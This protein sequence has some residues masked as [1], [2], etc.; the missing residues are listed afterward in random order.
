M[1]LF[2]LKNPQFRCVSQI[3]EEAESY[4]LTYE[5]V[6]KKMD[7]SSKNSVKAPAIIVS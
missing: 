1:K 3:N 5:M 6:T 7:K 4:K 2:I